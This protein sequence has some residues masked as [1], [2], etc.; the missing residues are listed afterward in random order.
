[1]QHLHWKQIIACC[2][3]LVISGMAVAQRGTMNQP[4]HDYETYWFGMNYGY[5]FSYNDYVR[6]TG[7]I[8]GVPKVGEITNIHHNGNPTF[9][10]GLS[11]TLRLKKKLL[12]RANPMVFIGAKNIDKFKIQTISGPS[13]EDY[14]ITPSTILHL[15]IALKLES[16]RYDFMNQ[17]NLMRHYVFGGVKMDYDFASGAIK[18]G[19]SGNNASPNIF[20]TTNMGYEL[21]LGLSF[22]LKYAT[23]SPEVK[24][25]YGVTDMKKTGTT[26]F[27]SLDKLHS[28]FVSFT[29]HLEN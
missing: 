24:F 18:Y 25:S 20:K 11:G 1:M 13:S 22:F 17:S 19:S 16:D 7:F 29:I 27:N 3:A 8:P 9:Q 15:P 14:L 21:G 28:N 5:A 12:L 26:F 4:D 10:L 6:G 2:I 23:I